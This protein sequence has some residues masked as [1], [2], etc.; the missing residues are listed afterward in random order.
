MHEYGAEYGGATGAIVNAITKGGTNAFHGRG[1]FYYQDS[2]LDG[3][4][5]FTKQAGGTKPDSGVKTLLGSVGG[6]IL[7]NKAFFFANVERL[8]IEQAAN[9]NYPPE[10]APLATSYS[11]ALPIKS[12]NIFSRVDYQV[13][14]SNSLN[15][16]ALFDPNAVNGQDHERDKRTISAMRIERAPKPGE[17]FWSGQWLGVIG[18]RMVNETRVY[19]VTENLHVGDQSL[20]DTGGNKV[21]SLEG[22]GELIGLGGRDQLDFGSGQLHPDF[23]AGPHE[24]PSG[25]SVVT[26]GFSDQFTYSPQSHTLKFGFGVSKN[27]G[28]NIVGGNYFGLFGFPGNR[29][30]D[31]AQVTT[32][33]NRFQMRL[34]ELFYPMKDWRTNFFVAD[35]WQATGKL[36][37]NMGV[38]YDYQHLIPQTKDAFAPRVGVAFAPNDKTVIR[39]GVGKFYEYQATAVASNLLLNAVISPTFQFDTGEDNSALQGALPAHPCLQPGGSEGL[40]AIGAACRAQ[41]VD[42]RNQVEAGTFVNSEPVLDG[43][44]KMGYLIGFS[45]GVQRELIPTVALTVDYVGNRGRDQTLRIDI[46]EPRLLANGRIGRP[47][48][49]VFDPDGTLIPAAARGTN[50]QKVL[51]YQTRPQFNTDYDAL[52]VGVQRRLSNRWSGRFA[53]TLSRARDVNGSTTGGGNI[54]EKRVNDDLDPRLDYGLGNTDN[55]HAFTS[56]A[57]W[58]A[59]RGLGIGTTFRYYSGN[60]VNE[61]LGRDANAD[62]D[63]ANF[64]RP[65]RGRDDATLAIVSPVDANGLAIRNGIKGRNKV[66]LDL[67]LQVRGQDRRGAV[68][69]ILL[70]NLQR[71]GSGQLRQS[72]RR[73]AVPV[74]HAVDRG[75]PAADDAARIAI[76]VL[77][78]APGSGLRAPGSRLR[79]SGSPFVIT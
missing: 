41:L 42:I 79:T 15:F 4:N 48:P 51:Q 58:D 53:Y 24:S 55:R 30:F 52:E 60:P 71:S 19:R 59:W 33:P 45:A 28:T 10:A 2:S 67:R 65:V 35:K 8:Q 5:Y 44:R 38:R 74:L 13:S 7:T 73:S 75:R 61:T 64:D 63:G 26:T 20:F 25:A 9:L 18:N 46:N 3:T 27:G 1:A 31:S 34:G 11:T 56:A 39:A 76:H 54:V 37:V 49:S 21:W 57:N 40:A 36:T 68:D 77:T 72:R 47:G 70:G 17:F 32:Y 62:R 43:D 29:P 78:R 22:G 69:G 23:Q 50:F 14:E 16:R 6:P 12:T 66:L